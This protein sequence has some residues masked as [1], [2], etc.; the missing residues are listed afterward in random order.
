MPG[1]GQEKAR[2][3]DI[4]SQLAKEKQEAL[5]AGLPFNAMDRA[6]ELISDKKT[7]LITESKKASRESLKKKTDELKIEYREDYTDETLKRLGVKS[8][9]DRKRILRITKEI[10]R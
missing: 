4:N 8:E 2:V 10:Q 9:D 5:N 6:M 1:F 3:A 7:T